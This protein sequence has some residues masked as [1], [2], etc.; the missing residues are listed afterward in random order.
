MILQYFKKKENEYKII[1]DKIYIR[2]LQSTKIL[3]K[4][5]YF[6]FINFDST[7]EILSIILIF[8]LWY[9]KD[10]NDK[11][12]KLI[13]DNIIRILINDLDKSLRDSGVSDMQIG[14]Y[15]KKFVKKFYFRLK[16]IDL[17]LNNFSKKKFEDYLMT[18]KNID[19]NAISEL[20]ADLIIIRDI[21]KKNTENAL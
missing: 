13:N 5:K 3:I 12:Y 16:K 18:V 15:V 2:S 9:L 10:S 19:I 8:N 21:I 6:K 14:K 11:K 20:T 4:K 7:F 17:I 1:S